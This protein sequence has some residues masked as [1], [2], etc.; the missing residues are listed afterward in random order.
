MTAPVFPRSFG[1][2]PTGILKWTVALPFFLQYFEQYPLPPMVRILSPTWAALCVVLQSV[3]VFALGLNY[4]LLLGVT[5][6]KCWLCCLEDKLSLFPWAFI[7]QVSPWKPL[8]SL[9]KLAVGDL[10]MNPIC[11]ILVFLVD[12]L[13]KNAS[14]SIPDIPLP[15]H[16]LWY[17]ICFE[18]SRVSCVRDVNSTKRK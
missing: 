8:P 18:I 15:K 17:F 16:S 4:P 13:L 10:L 2:Q 5:R 9:W 1:V 6:E 12:I 3:S 7:P 11:I 14:C